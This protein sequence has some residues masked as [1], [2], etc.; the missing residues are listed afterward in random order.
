V[1]ELVRRFQD[2]EGALGVDNAGPERLQL[3]KN[4]EAA[5][6]LFTAS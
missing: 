4:R 3:S 5:N 1:A 2:F 6:W